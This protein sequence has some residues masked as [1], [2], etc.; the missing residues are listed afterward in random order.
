MENLPGSATVDAVPL[1]DSN[2]YKE[3][4]AA[5]LNHFEVNT[6]TYRQRF[7]RD[8]K[9]PGESFKGFLGR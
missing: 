8:I 5:I 4:K 9:K 6:K 1:A 2:K 7:G 3:V